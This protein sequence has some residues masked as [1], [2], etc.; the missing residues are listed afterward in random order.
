ML[1]ALTEEMELI[2]C[3]LRGEA[4]SSQF[5]DSL[6]WLHFPKANYAKQRN[7]RKCCIGIFCPPVRHT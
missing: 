7:N 6:Y 5:D 2:H 1:T 3:A 4:E